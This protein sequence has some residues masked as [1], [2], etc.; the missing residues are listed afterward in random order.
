MDI[1]SEIASPTTRNRQVVKGMKEPSALGQVRKCTSWPRSRERNRGI[2]DYLCEVVVNPIHTSMTQESIFSSP[3]ICMTLHWRHGCC[4]RSRRASMWQTPVP[5][6]A[7]GSWTF[8]CKLS[9]IS[10]R[11]LRISQVSCLGCL[12]WQLG[13]HMGMQITPSVQLLEL[14]HKQVWGLS[15]PAVFSL[16]KVLES[17]STQIKQFMHF[18]V[19]ETAL[20]KLSNCSWINANQ[21]LR[22]ARNMSTDEGLRNLAEFQNAGVGWLG[23]IILS[24]W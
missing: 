10:A 21:G 14:S 4:V 9:E 18:G 17:Q 3:V 24:K 16:F 12:Y 8:A 1:Y 23:S 22:I 2:T 7:V 11:R 20:E 6:F 15:F 19:E 13:P 5:P